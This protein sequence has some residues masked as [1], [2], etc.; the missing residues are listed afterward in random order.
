M[1]FST[2]PSQKVK[3]G[4]VSICHSRATKTN[5]NSL[6]NEEKQMK[7]ATKAFIPNQISNRK[8]GATSVRRVPQAPSVHTSPLPFLP[9]FNSF[10]LQ[11]G[12]GNYLS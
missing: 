6:V 9:F 12:V 1:Y 2:G 4:P 3:F 5:F 8:S 10:F 11:L 7:S